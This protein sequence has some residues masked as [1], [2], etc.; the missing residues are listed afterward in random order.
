[1]ARG[2]VVVCT[3][4]STSERGALVALARRLAERL[5][6]VSVTASARDH[7]PLAFA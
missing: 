4:H 1:V 2:L 7:D 5:P 6:G 3:R